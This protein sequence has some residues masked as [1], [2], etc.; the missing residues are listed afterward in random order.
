MKRQ[1]FSLAI[2]IVLA[3]GSALA[4]PVETVLTSDSTLYAIESD[5]PQPFLEIVKRVGTD[6]E[7]ILVPGSADATVE[8]SDGRLAWD[9]RTNTLYV[10]WHRRGEQSDEIVVSSRGPAGEWSEPV[11]VSADPASRH[12]G[13]QITLAK[14]VYEEV[15]STLIHTAWWALGSGDPKAEYALIAFTGGAHASTE[16]LSLDELARANSEGPAEP[17]DTGR[18]MHPPLAMERNG[19][20]VVVVFGGVETTTLNRVRVTPVLKKAGEARMWKP[21]G[22]TGERVPRAYLTS[23][24]TNP[25]QAFVIGGRIVLYT[26][27]S[28]F[29]YVVFDDGQWSPARMIALDEKLTSDKMLHELRKAVEDHTDP[30]EITDK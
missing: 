3:A 16:P 12:E 14:A 5:S 28:T 19:S 13:L 4:S 7:T 18:A 10:V 23:L 22:R 20:G 24:T 26:P 29:R 9:S 2:V 17:E 15:E 30:D 27:D 25:V 6:R 11:T 1:L 21:L 8:D